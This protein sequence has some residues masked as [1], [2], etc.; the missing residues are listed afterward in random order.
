MDVLRVGD[1]D[2]APEVTTGG[3]E[4]IVGTWQTSDSGRW[5]ISVLSMLYSEQ[6]I[7]E[8]SLKCV[9]SMCYDYS[10]T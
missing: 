10:R 6:R 3:Q 1:C 8:P 9:L 5:S 4:V 2:H 7:Y